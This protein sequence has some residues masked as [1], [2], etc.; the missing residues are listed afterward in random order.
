MIVGTPVATNVVGTATKVMF[1]PAMI[2]GT[3]VPTII[4][5]MAYYWKSCMGEG[6][7]SA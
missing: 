3:V 1:V 7:I 2:V 4:V 6:G 5:L